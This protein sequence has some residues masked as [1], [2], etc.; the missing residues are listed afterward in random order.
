MRGVRN[1]LGDRERVERGGE[2]RVPFS[3]APPKLKTENP[4][5]KTE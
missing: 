3:L 2:E 1:E 5:L 4:K